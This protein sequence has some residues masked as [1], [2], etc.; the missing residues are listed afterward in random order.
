VLRAGGYDGFVS[1]EWGGSAWCEAGE[2]DGFE[3]VRAH[4]VLCEQALAGDDGLALGEERG[5][6]AMT[7]ESRR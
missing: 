4:R 3:A 1:S 6:L 5:E 7:T 2:V